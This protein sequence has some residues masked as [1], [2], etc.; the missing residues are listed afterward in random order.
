M[1]LLEEFLDELRKKG[2]QPKYVRPARGSGTLEDLL[3][4]T[5]PAPPEE[6]EQFVA[7]IYA[8]RREAEQDKPV[9]WDE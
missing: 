7:N 9:H 3:K 6:A 8:D 4:H 2:Y 5:W 1:T